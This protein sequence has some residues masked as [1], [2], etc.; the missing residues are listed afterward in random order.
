MSKIILSFDKFGHNQFIKE[1]HKLVEDY[2]SY[3]EFNDIID[4]NFLNF[5]KGVFTNPI[6]KRKINK[7]SND[8]LKTKIELMKIEIEEDNISSFK[9]QINKRNADD[10]GYLISQDQI[11]V[12][13]RSK[14][15]KI[16]ALQDREEAIIDQMDNIGKES[17]TL[18]KYVD[19]IKFDIRIKA[20]DATIRIADGETERILRDLKK[21][22]LNAV[23]SLNK[24][25][26]I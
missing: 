24:E 21:Q 14:A 11:D 5:I 18:Q 3:D 25:L 15:A 1:T 4:E 7:L 13:D 23:R 2:M 19:K 22:D 10:N 8:L 20:N 6:Q 26:D 12:A 9:S 17:E 16:K